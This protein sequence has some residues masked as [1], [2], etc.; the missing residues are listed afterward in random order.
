MGRD[1][2]NKRQRQR[3]DESTD[4]ESSGRRQRRSRSKRRRQSE[5]KGARRRVHESSRRSRSRESSNNEV[6]LAE[7][8]HKTPNT[9]PAAVVTVEQPLAASTSGMV[10]N[11]NSNL[12]FLLAFKEM[13]QTM[14]TEGSSDKF[15]NLNV[16]PEFDPTKRNQTIEN[17]I[18][19]V[20]ECTLIYN[21][22][23]RQTIHYALPKLTGLA[24]KWYQGLRSLLFSWPEWQN[25]LKLAF[26]SDENYGQLLSEMLLCKAKYGDSLEEYFYE[27][28]VLLN[29]CNINSK[30]AIDC[31]LFG[32]EDRSV[33]TSAEAAQF[34]EP[35][36]LLVYLRNVKT[37]K[38]VDRDHYRDQRNINQSMSD[39]KI[40]KNRVYVNSD[41]N[42]KT[43]SKCYNC[44]E[45][46]HSYFRCKQPLKKCDFCKKVG[47]LGKDCF[48]KTEPTNTKS[49]NLGNDGD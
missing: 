26:P 35:D 38:R 4:S 5:S 41:N 12:D 42:I 10:N 49:A 46:G 33:R 32:I 27:K 47:H 6:E 28:M 24:Q 40:P 48:S 23:E 20:N 29:R 8:G 30:N 17:W 13:I 34:T 18:S 3:R 19:K 14:K 22:N 36:K 1:D 37:I 21:W 43:T 16:I 11:N 39:N 15:P 9:L 44:G 31:I 25:K 45:E 7:S 2:V